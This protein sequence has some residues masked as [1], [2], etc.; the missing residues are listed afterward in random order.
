LVDGRPNRSSSPGTQSSQTPHRSL[1]LAK[2]LDLLF[3]FI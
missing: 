1:A 3:D 2:Q